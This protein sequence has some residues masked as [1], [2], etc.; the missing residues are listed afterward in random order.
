MINNIV[1][2]FLARTLGR[3]CAAIVAE[4]DPDF[5]IGGATPYLLR[6]WL[7]PRN[8]I[9]NVYLHVMLRDDDDRALHDHPWSSLSLLLGS[10]QDGGFRK[11]GVLWEVFSAGNGLI[12]Q[13]RITA[14]ALVYRSARF[15]HRLVVP[16]AGVMTIF[17][18]GPRVREWG[19]W[20]ER[21]WRHWEEF[22]AAR[23]GRPGSIG[24]G[25][26]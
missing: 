25:C 23:D 4:R 8:K 1:T 6:W 21:G 3:K 24:K 17:V 7:V 22:T 11:S 13:R 18:T 10:V 19:F 15:A 16:Q 14:G 20:C 2:A 9:F 26:D 12:T 5:V